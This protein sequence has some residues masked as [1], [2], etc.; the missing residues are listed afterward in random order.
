MDVLLVRVAAEDEL[1]LGG[2]HEFADHVLDV[3]TDNAFGG[4]KIA[5]T[6]ADDPTLDLGE[7]LLIA[8]LLDVFAHRDI[9]G[10]PVVGLHLAVKIVGPLIFQ[11]EQVEAHGL[12]TVNH[13]FGGKRSFSLGL[14]ED[15]SLGSNIE[16]FLH[17][18]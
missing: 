3:V 2:G 18:I 6:H 8:P 13:A 15:E 12:T 7:G 17:G 4:R 1:E 10:L 14:V 5:D 16:G 11:R 9:L